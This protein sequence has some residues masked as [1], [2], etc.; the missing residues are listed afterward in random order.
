MPAQRPPAKAASPGAHAPSAAALHMPLSM[1]AN[2]RE[3]DAFAKC[4]GYAAPEILSRIG[5]SVAPDAWRRES[6]PRHPT[7]VP[8]NAGE[9]TGRA[10]GHRADTF[11]DGLLGVPYIRVVTDLLPVC[12]DLAQA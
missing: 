8:R 4:D 2:R 7:L 9:G 11:V 3:T 1:A 6:S 12:G 5:G 10:T